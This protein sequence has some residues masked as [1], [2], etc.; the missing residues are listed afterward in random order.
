MSG[1]ARVLCALG[2]HDLLETFTDSYGEYC[3]R[4]GARPR[5]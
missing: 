5:E 2:R 3:R 4:C 1:L